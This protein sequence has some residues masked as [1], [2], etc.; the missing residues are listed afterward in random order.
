M[1]SKMALTARLHSKYPPAE[2]EALSL[3]APR[4]GLNARFAQPL[5]RLWRS[6]SQPL[7]SPC[8]AAFCKKGTA[9][10]GP[11][12]HTKN[13]AGLQPLRNAR[14]ASHH[15][16]E[17]HARFAQMSTLY[18][19]PGKA[20]GSPMGQQVF[21]PSF[22][23]KTRCYNTAMTNEGAV[24]A[25]GRPR[26][27]LVESMGSGEITELHPSLWEVP[28]PTPNWRYYG[29]VFQ[30][31]E[32]HLDIPNLRFYITWDIDKLPEYGPHVVVL[33]LVEEIS[34]VPH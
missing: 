1:I 16:P 12:P 26:Y 4:R 24:P 32:R 27:F 19:H 8:C 28:C 33:L 23:R 5:R 11:K 29:R 30:E 17:H 3:V 2:P 18:C 25:E 13:V 14:C 15:S 9:S 22:S 21:L 20:G 10:A 6:A 31:M 7:C 34:R